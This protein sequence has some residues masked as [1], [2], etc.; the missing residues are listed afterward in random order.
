ME[1][2]G[3]LCQIVGGSTNLPGCLQISSAKESKHNKKTTPARGRDATDAD[4]VR[5]KKRKILKC[6][7]KCF[8]NFQN[9]Q[10]YNNNNNKIV[11]LPTRRL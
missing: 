7:E 4:S 11:T 10:S 3:I 2:F 6:Y 1:A 9:R 5:V 8:S